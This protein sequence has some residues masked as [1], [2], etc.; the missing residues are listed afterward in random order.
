M[1]AMEKVVWC[2]C[3]LLLGLVAFRLTTTKRGGNGGLRLPPGPWRLPVVGNLHQ[4]MA[5]GPL[6]HRTMADMARRLG[7][8]LMS[9]RLGEV[10]VVVA[11]SADAAREIMRTHDA[12]FAT[13]PWN[14]TTRRL[15]PDGEGVHEQRRAHVAAPADGAMEEEE[16]EDLVDVLF[17][18]QKDGGLEVPLTMGN[19]KAIILDLFNAGSETSANTLQWV[20]SELMRNPKVMKKVQAELRNNLQG[21]ATVTEDDLPNLKDTKYWDMPEMFIPER[22]DNCIIDFKGT[23]FEFIPFGAGRRMC[24]GIAFAQFNMELVL[25]ALL[26]HFDWELPS[27]MLPEELD[28]MED[29]GL[30]VRR[31]NDLYLVCLCRL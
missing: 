11:S 2:L 24:P 6:V 4:V 21:K 29:M 5:R 27:G 22:F 23:D 28:M 15:R 7:A 31:K 1:D 20:M 18:I 19:I 10:P 3:F 26:Y 16:E 12:R 14:P 8:P 17:R 25:A 13:R 30:S 9:L